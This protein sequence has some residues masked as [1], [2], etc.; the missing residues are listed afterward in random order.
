MI[1]SKMAGALNKQINAEMYA[2]YLYLSMSSYSAYKG[3]DG[4]AKWLSLQAM[5]EMAHAQK[6][7]GYV[8][9]QGS[10]VLL[11]AIEKPPS[12]FKSAKDIFAKTLAHE[13]KVT[14]SINALVNLAVKEKDHATHA[15]L[16][17]FV[18]EQVEEEEHAG[19]IL[20]R[21]ELAGDQVGA[22][23]MLDREL[24]ARSSSPGG[25]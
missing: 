5:E 10:R 21:F 24:G 11:G 7:Y 15:F 25:E 2:A 23:F 14:A 12:E 13:K 17:W 9:S 1:S 20:S 3:L 18:T 6:I 16:Q 22:L 4:I 8:N 19:M